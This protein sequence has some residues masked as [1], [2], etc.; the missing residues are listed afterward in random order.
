VLPASSGHSS[1]SPFFCLLQPEGRGPIPLWLAVPPERPTGFDFREKIKCREQNLSNNEDFLSTS[2]LRNILLAIQRTASPTV[3]VM[4][5]SFPR[6][7]QGQ[8][9]PRFSL[10]SKIFE[11]PGTWLHL[12]SSL[13]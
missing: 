11:N 12:T 1:E 7:D 5:I 6:A 3:L 8:F 9:C 13:R 10:L 4:K 2:G